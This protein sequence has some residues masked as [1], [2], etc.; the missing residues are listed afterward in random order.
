ME[1][2]QSQCREW[3]G[4]DFKP[5]FD[6]PLCYI[7]VG[8]LDLLFTGTCV[9]ELLALVGIVQVPPDA[10][11]VFRDL[12][13]SVLL[14]HHLQAKKKKNNWNIFLLSSSF[15]TAHNHIKRSLK[16]QNNILKFSL[17]F[18]IG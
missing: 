3:S 1:N 6:K 5:L 18:S 8:N 16:A 14:C 15:S 17:I 10:H 13:A 11:H 12:K 9:G 7:S 4:G 2:K